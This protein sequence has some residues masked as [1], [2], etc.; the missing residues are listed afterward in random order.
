MYF[1]L[2]NEPKIVTDRKETFAMIVV[3]EKRKERVW[4]F[5]ESDG[6]KEMNDLESHFHY[7]N[8][9]DLIGCLKY[10]Y[11]RDNGLIIRIK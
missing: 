5:T 2:I 1:F 3:R 4:I 7:D 8:S 6:F 10:K 11:S 9:H